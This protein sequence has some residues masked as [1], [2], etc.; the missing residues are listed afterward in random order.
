AFSARAESAAQRWSASAL[1]GGIGCAA[2]VA[3]ATAGSVPTFAVSGGP[4][5]PDSRGEEQLQGAEPA[6]RREGRRVAVRG[7]PGGVVRTT[8]RRAFTA[9][10][11]PRQAPDQ[12]PAHH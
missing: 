10:A 11:G 12:L 5:Q 1:R 9:A 3:G 8:T 7:A 4:G 2:F 6:D